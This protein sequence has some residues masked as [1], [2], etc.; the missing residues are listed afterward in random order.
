MNFI[1]KIL[2]PTDCSEASIEAL[3]YSIKIAKAHRAEL[4]VLH[5][6]SHLENTA[7]YSFSDKSVSSFKDDFL[8]AKNQLEKFWEAIGGNEIETDLELGFGDPFTEIMRYAK[9]KKNDVIVMGTHGRIGLKHFLMGSVAEKVVR[10]SPIP[11]VTV[12]HKS[13]EFFPKPGY[14]YDLNKRY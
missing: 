6:V 3:N 9:S 4:M 7:S 8:W 11:V 14:E 2:A 10:Y 5:V 12:K 13:Y 1:S